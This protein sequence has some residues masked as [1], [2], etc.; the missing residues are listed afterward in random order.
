MIK[1]IDSDQ[2]QKVI[3]QPGTLLLKFTAAWCGPCKMQE[4]ILKQLDIKHLPNL[5][6]AEI[7]IDENKS[8]AIDYGI[9]SIP[10]MII[11]KN[12]KEVNRLIGVHPLSKLLIELNK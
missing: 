8:T 2:L 5:N 10:A 7:D 3:N 12:G 11:F 1:E 6:I 9:Q 4:V